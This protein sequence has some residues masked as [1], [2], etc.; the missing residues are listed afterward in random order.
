MKR[1]RRAFL[2]ET[3]TAV[4]V[5]RARTLNKTVELAVA[6]Q[7]KRKG[8]IK[9]CDVSATASPVPAT[10]TVVSA[11]VNLARGSAGLNNFEGNTLFPTS[12]EGK[13]QIVST[14]PNAFLRVMVVQWFDS[15]I[16][17]PTGILQSVATGFGTMSPVSATNRTVMRV[18]YDVT[19]TLQNP[20]ISPAVAL[21][22][23]RFYI[24]ASKLRPLRINPTATALQDGGIY[25]LYVSDDTTSTYPN[26]AF[27]N[28][29]SFTD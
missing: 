10:G 17:T 2:A 15:S 23:G 27:F 25:I 9:Y 18:L 24:P 11:T 29:I 16:P 21:A 6:R 13:Y 14:E 26:V 28:R 4:P 12:F 1:P 7:L 8:D 22:K 19:H 3:Q 20:D 5:K